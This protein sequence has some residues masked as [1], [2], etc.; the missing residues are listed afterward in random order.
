MKYQP[1]RSTARWLE[2]APRPVLACYDNGGKT[3]DRYTIIYGA[4]LWEPNMGRT[5]PY[6]S[7]SE[8]PF[9]P[10]G[11]GQWGEMPAY[12]RDCLGRKV[13][14]SDLPER[15]RACVEQDCRE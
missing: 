10:Q 9:H 12:N 8:D 4:P 2:G 1:K 13:K 3:F 5:V 6:R 15:V 14:F 11:F 7:M